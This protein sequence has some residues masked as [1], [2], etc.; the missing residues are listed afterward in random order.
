V[1]LHSKAKHG[2]LAFSGEVLHAQRRILTLSRDLGWDG[3]E[4]YDYYEVFCLLRKGK[5][6][7][8]GDEMCT[9]DVMSKR[10]K[11]CTSE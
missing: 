9:V 8:A 5:S 2:H 10:K 11:K 6:I 3:H 4:G 1:Q 7:F